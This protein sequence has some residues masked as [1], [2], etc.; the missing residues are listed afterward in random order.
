MVQ[1]ALYARVSTT[2]QA[3]TDTIA[4]QISA[5]ENRITEDGYTLLEQLKFIDNGYSGSNLV[6]P[7]LE[8]LRDKVAAGE[9]D[10]VYIHSPDRLSRKY[11]YQMIIMEE[12]KNAGVEI[13]FLNFQSDDNPESQLLLQMQGMIA[14]YERTK[15]LERSR[16]GKIFAAKR[17]AVNAL[18]C[19]PYGYRYIDV[20]SGRGEAQYEINEE[21]AQIIQKM[22]AWIG[23]ER[24]SVGQVRHR[25]SDLNIP[26]PKGNPRWNNA[27]IYHVLR[28]PAYKGQAAFGK[29]KSG[30]KL[31]VIRPQKNATNHSRSH[32]SVCGT[33]KK[34]WIYIPVPAII[35]ADLFAVA[36]E[37]LKDNRKLARVRQH[38]AT[39]LLQ[40]LVVCSRCRYAYCGM[41]VKIRRRTDP[42]QSQ[43]NYYRCTGTQHYHSDGNRV[44]DNKSI[45][46][47]VLD[48]VVWEEVKILL[49]DPN[50][51]IH[52]YR[53][54]MEELEKSPQD[55]T[56]EFLEKQ[57]N[58]L[59]N[60]ISRL[61]DSYTQGHISKEEF[62]PRIK[63]LR[64]NLNGV[65]EQNEKLKDQKNLRKEL[66]LIVT[67]LEDFS[68]KIKSGLE[69]V[70]WDSKRDIIRSLVKRIE[71]NY[72]EVN[73]VFRIKELAINNASNNV[74]HNN[75]QYHCR[76]TS[77]Q[78]SRAKVAHD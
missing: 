45:R 42:K 14:E 10:R 44:C 5:L 55:Q 36:Q 57:Q 70:D 78:P 51:L 8:L 20:H 38:G 68:S 59:K 18:G 60:S 27:S 63:V 56:I 2:G 6:R 13:I 77:A 32:R 46:T 28:N 49:N 21:E 11:A 73:I 29:T 34:D 52:E 31:P 69:A 17:G 1:A 37:Q 15:I 64:Q 25:L 65:E 40:G 58:K 47:D 76:R 26:S 23:H 39:T 71:L 74:G 67:N 62:E 61:I 54:R 16:R 24:F 72:E 30:P 19:A 50:R 66:T 53:R 4:S 48:T 9:V 3:Q 75:L 12:F 22:F 35:D 43:H 33:D 7:G 41:A